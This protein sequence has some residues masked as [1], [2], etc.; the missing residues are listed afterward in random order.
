MLN[1]YF[2]SLFCLAWAMKKS[3]GIIYRLCLS[4]PLNFFN[5]CKGILIHGTPKPM[6]S[7]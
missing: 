7:A 3:K 6:L 5:I 2:F 1:N 4:D